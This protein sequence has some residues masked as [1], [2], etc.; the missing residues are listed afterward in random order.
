MIEHT[1]TCY[2]YCACFRDGAVERQSMCD[3]NTR[4]DQRLNFLKI[5]IFYLMFVMSMIKRRFDAA[6]QFRVQDMF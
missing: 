6:Q 1:A 4:I 5:I 2:Y 3:T